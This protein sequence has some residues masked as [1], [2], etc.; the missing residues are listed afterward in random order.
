MYPALLALGLVLANCTGKDTVSISAVEIEKG[1]ENGAHIRVT[2]DQFETMKMQWGSPAQ[3]NFASELSVQGQV[4]VPVE[5]IQEISAYFGGYVSGLKLLEGQPI[6]KGQLLFYLENPDFIRLQQDFLEAQSQLT[7]LMEE[8]ERQKT[9]YSEQI[10]AQKSFLKAEADYLGTKTKAES[11]KKQLALIGIDAN[12]LTPEKI[13]SIIQVNSPVSG[14]VESID[15][16]PGAFL[17]AA[18]KALTLISRE[19]LHVELTVFERDAT[20]ISVGQKVGVTIPGSR[21]QLYEAEVIMVGQAINTGRQI[22][23]HADLVNKADEN[24]L[25]PG[26][27]VEAKI[28]QSPSSGWS[29]PE[30]ALVETE[31]GYVL[32]LRGEATQNG[33]LL[34]KLPVEIGRQNGDRMEVFPNGPMDENSVILVKGGFNLV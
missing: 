4:Q 29:V 32:L 27:F 13:S 19:H 1:S 5:G 28:Q 6:R 15:I 23:V 2:N 16:V 34:E 3:Q 20:S 25:I 10:A 26:M 12:Q 11:F 18:G 7:Y 21:E 24:K 14:F 31:D 22:N 33:Y 17:P 30:S 9:L 8:Y